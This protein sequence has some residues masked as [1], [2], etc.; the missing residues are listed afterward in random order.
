M[1][2]ST[3]SS[4]RV[5]FV[6]RFYFPDHSATAQILT[7]IATHLAYKDLP[8]TVFCT[9]L[10]YS[11]DAVYAKNE[12]ISG[13]EIRRLWTSRFGRETWLGRGIDY[14]TFYLGVCVSLFFFLSKDDVLIA[15]TDP[16]M[17]SVPLG[18]IARLKRATRVNWLQD[19]FPEVALSISGK[20]PDNFVVQSL[21]RLRNRSLRKA[22]KNVAIGKTMESMVVKMGVVPE[23][24]S[25]IHNFVD[26]E[27]ITP[28]DTHA[29][30]LR[31][32]W[33][34]KPD[35]FVVGY[36]G[37]LGRAHDLDTIL[38][39]A[40]NLRDHEK[41]KFLFIG[42]GF[43]RE[44]LQSELS[45]R[46]LTNVVLKPYMPREALPDS[47]SLPNLHWASLIPSLE[48]YIVPSKVYGVAAAGRPL[49][50]IGDPNG[51]ISRMIAHFDFGL[52]VPCGDSR[53]A[54]DV[55]LNLYS[56]KARLRALGANARAFIEG[57]ASRKLAQ[58][59]WYTLVQSALGDRR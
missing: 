14:L 38:T 20:T 21:I 32:S 56:D 36:S 23:K 12:T 54:S 42:G 33:G 28:K 59:R 47:L 27:S 6:N 16:P 22:D 3:S 40:M 11:N 19:I 9:R 8:V 46:N 7:D 29:P 35:D 41:I 39:A 43:L 55:I 25:I 44:R 51:E 57:N 10:S 45:V 18:L 58:K 4:P 53:G 1:P 52:N 37:N 2:R 15:K 30:L 48:G 13:V 34:L 49:L 50:M 24:V 31:E 17:L 5:I 26:D